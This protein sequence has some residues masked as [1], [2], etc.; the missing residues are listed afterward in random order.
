MCSYYGAGIARC[1]KFPRDYSARDGAA[2]EDNRREAW[3]I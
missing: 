1:T 3:A 2:A